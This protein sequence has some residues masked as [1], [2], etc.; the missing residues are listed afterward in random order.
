MKMV[1][2]TK[3]GTYEIIKNVKDAFDIA[4]FEERYIEEC[5]DRFEVLVGDVSSGILRI[6]GF[7]ANDKEND[8]RFIPDYLSESCAFGCP[9][10]ILQRLKKGKD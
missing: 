9:Y 3:F 1:V 7:S 8:V 2:E 4:K 10:Y 5:F 6:K